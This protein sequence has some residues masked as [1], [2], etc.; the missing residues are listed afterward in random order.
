M[1]TVSSQP[2]EDIRAELQKNLLFTALAPE[3][4]DRLIESTRIIQLEAG[5]TLFERGDAAERFFLVVYGQIK[6]FRI[7]PQ[8]AEKVVEIMGPGDTFAEAVMFMER[9][10]YPVSTQ[11]MTVSRL[12]AI[13]NSVYRDLLR[14]SPDSCF[15]LMADMSSR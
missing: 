1:K 2:G 10:V 11:A 4:L 7:S 5:E 9:H 3:A 6:L 14:E 12:Y 8:G 13:S 15:R